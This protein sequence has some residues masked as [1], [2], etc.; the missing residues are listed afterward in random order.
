MADWYD[1]E[2]RKLQ[3]AEEAASEDVPNNADRSG[4]TEK[5]R[6]IENVAKGFY[7]GSG[8]K[9]GGNLP[10]RKT[11]GGSRGKGGKPGFGNVFKKGGP[12]ATITGIIGIVGFLTLGSQTLMPTAIQEMIVQKFNSIGVSSTMSS[13]AWL[14]TQ[15]KR[16]LRNGLLAAGDED[17]FA[18]SDHQVKQFEA[19]GMKV[20]QTNSSGAA[21]LY[22]KNGQWVPVVNSGSVGNAGLADEIASLTGFSDIGSPVSSKTAMADLDFK[23]SYTSA[24]K[25]WRGGGSGWFDELMEKVTQKKLAV[26]RNRWVGYSSKTE[27]E[28]TDEFKSTAASD[29]KDKTSDYEVGASKEMDDDEYKN[30]GLAVGST[31]VPSESDAD[32]WSSSGNPN[33]EVMEVTNITEVEHFDEEGNKLPSTWI[34]EADNNAES[35]N[36]VRDVGALETRLSNKAV[37]AGTAAARGADMACSIV[38]GMMAIYTVAAAYQSLQFLNLSSGFLEAVD[39]VKAGDGT[40]SPVHEYGNSLATRADTI[41][42]NSDGSQ[43]VVARKTAME[44]AGAAWLFSDASIN[45]ND[46][47]VS[48]VNFESIMSNMSLLTG[49][50][51]AVAGTVNFTADVFETC[52]Y[53][54]IAGAGVDLVTEIVST[55]MMFIPIVGQ[56]AKF[57]QVAI[58]I[59]KDIAL[60][61]AVSA[62]FG[63]VI[64]V[65][66]KK[67]VA[68]IIKDAATEWFGEDLGN[69]LISGA[70]KYLGGNGSSGGQGPGSKTK[71]LAY[72]SAQQ[73]VIAEEAEYQRS[74]RSPFDVS[75]PHTFLGTLAYSVLPLAYSSSGIMSTLTDVSS[76]MTSSVVSVLPTASAFEVNGTL[77]S[78]GDCPILEG[79]GAVGDAYCNPIIITDTNTIAANPIQIEETAHNVVD[80]KGNKLFDDDGSIN[81]KSDLAKYITFCGQRTSQ[82]GLKDSGIVEDLDAEIESGSSSGGGFLSWLQ[83]LIGAVPI[84][85]ETQTILEGLAE[86]DVL[87]WATG[88][89]CV[90]SDDNPYWNNSNP[91][92]G[93][94]QLYQRYAENQ[95]LVEN[96]NP[97]YTSTVTAYLENYY[98][99]NP[100]DESFEGT[101]ARFSG[102][103]KEQVTDTLALMEYYQFIGEYNALAR[104]DFTHTEEPEMVE[105][106]FSNNNVVAVEAILPKT[107]VYLDLRNRQ[108][109]TA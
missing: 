25:T 93:D 67:V 17:L 3:A 35:I 42:T 85:G 69:A 86:Q 7:S 26:K 52:G 65:V 1:E 59:G 36:G 94:G 14:D 104:H 83:T 41:K 24:S 32:G 23:K 88:E 8:K 61:L 107:L 62:F 63:A 73:E 10:S 28:M 29:V 13:D 70:S 27:G 16:G 80:S 48:N 75:S 105:I 58:S 108:A 90:V 4:A 49:G 76:L 9:T 39:K 46:V 55:G 20:V 38:E 100:I 5:L 84:L 71:V 106:E 91:N 37:K 60:N 57:T 44:S 92:V 31:V 79:T 11:G 95:R 96:M 68:A 99:E 101:L 43:E 12:A 66:A 97:G 102:M 33:G 19:N 77:S 2:T 56:A 87:Q 98:E 45:S 30:S 64:P 53:A 81:K 40:K 6:G 51:A 21:V 74:I 47:S 50:I 22:R 72:L 18:L 103:T 78:V 109:T 54:K 82:Y 15:L 89:A 34:V